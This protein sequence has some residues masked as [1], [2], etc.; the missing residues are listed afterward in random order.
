MNVEPTLRALLGTGGQHPCSIRWWRTERK[1]RVANQIILAT[2]VSI[3]YPQHEGVSGLRVREL[4]VQRFT[5]GPS[6]SSS[7][8][9]ANVSQRTPPAR[10]AAAAIDCRGTH[11]TIANLHLYERIV[12]PDSVHLV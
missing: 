10:V 8:S 4:E 7:S 1:R 2:E 5:G 6:S 11:S 12:L 3:K 9:S